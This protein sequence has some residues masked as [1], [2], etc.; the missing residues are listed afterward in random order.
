M[1]SAPSAGVRVATREGIRGMQTV[2]PGPA[3]VHWGY[4]DA[5]LR[6][7]AEVGD[8]ETFH[9]RSVAGTPTDPVPPDWIPPEIPGI[10]E[11][12]HDRGD[13]PHLLTGPIRVRGAKPGDVLQV[14]ILSIAL[15]AAYGF[16][17]VRPGGGL[18]PDATDKAQVHYIPLD[19]DRG[20]A[21]VLP[22][23]T[24]PV[25][26]FF[27]VVGVAP[28][29]KRGRLT[30]RIPGAH[31][32]NLDNKELVGGAT[33]FLPVFEEGALFSAGDGHAAQGDG[34]VNIT[35][36][37]TCLEGTF[38]LRV[39]S[40]FG[41]ALP[42]ALTSTHLITM[43]FDED[44]D[45]A[46]QVAVRAMLDLVEEH[47]GVAWLDAYRLASI[48]ADLRV[49]QVVNGVKG[50]HVMLAREILDQLGQPAPFLIPPA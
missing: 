43:G 44:L 38:R 4:F 50:I 19:R 45:R 27:G 35:A 12:V 20:L 49:T 18:F 17:V 9:L 48:A 42:I 13:V 47:Y 21:T 37:E 24:V 1:D 2:L 25:R 15:G 23:V 26:P 8:G 11:H 7:V 6:P 3:T 32:G 39:R 14:E 41:L 10:Y 22:S 16:N 5:S 36:I 28:P 29:A 46:A 31:G 33:L 40:D 30:S 34:E